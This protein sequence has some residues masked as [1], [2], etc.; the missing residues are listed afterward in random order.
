M[1]INI[2][3]GYFPS[4]YINPCPEVPRS[5][6]Y[7]GSMN[8]PCLNWYI[9]FDFWLIFLEKICVKSVHKHGL[10]PEDSCFN[11]AGNAPFDNP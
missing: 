6:I 8:I 3:L 2:D 7:V 9:F 11:Y 4:P 10:L 1:K 5:Y